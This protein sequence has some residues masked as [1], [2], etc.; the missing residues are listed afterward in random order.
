MKKVCNAKELWS[1]KD[2]GFFSALKKHTQY[3]F[4]FEVIILI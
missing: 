4:F 1:D 2:M 3:Y